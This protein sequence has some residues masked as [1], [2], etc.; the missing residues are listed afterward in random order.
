MLELRYG[1]I[2]SS[3]VCWYWMP[4]SVQ[5]WKANYREPERPHKA[6]L[7]NMMQPIP[8]EQQRLQARMPE[9]FSLLCSSVGSINPFFWHPNAKPTLP[10]ASRPLSIHTGLQMAVLAFHM[11]WPLAKELTK[12]I[13]DQKVIEEDTIYMGQKSN[14]IIILECCCN[15]LSFWQ[16]SI[17]CILFV[18]FLHSPTLV[19]TA[20]IE[21]S[22]SD[23]RTDCWDVLG[24]LARS[25]GI[26]MVHCHQMPD[27]H[28]CRNIFDHW[29]TRPQERF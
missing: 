19:A 4:S 23:L 8:L 1:Q 10:S 22:C 7:K 25:F 24:Q 9:I 15:T 28:L 29:S 16:I 17:F 12:I 11:V 2:W 26:F 20:E 5:Q 27:Q 18:P 6:R 14:G 3:P 13:T 21:K